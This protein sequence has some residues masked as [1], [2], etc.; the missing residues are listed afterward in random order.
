M[1]SFDAF[2]WKLKFVMEIQKYHMLM[3]PPIRCNETQ[4]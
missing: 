3:V 4:N 2:I 1:F